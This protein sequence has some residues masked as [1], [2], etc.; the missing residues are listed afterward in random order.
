MR[1]ASAWRWGLALLGIALFGALAMRRSTGWIV[2]QHLRLSG[3]PAS[4]FGT[5]V[6]VGVKELPGGYQPPAGARADFNRR[7]A[8]AAE[9]LRNDPQV[10][11]AY[12]LR[13]AAW[14]ARM[15]AGAEE[16]TQHAAAL[17]PLLARF[18]ADPAVPATMV[19]FDLQRSILSNRREEEL[20]S[21]ASRRRF[22]SLEP[23]PTPLQLHEYDKL[24][25]RGERLAPANALFP[26][27]R[28][29]GQLEA[30]DDRAA[31]ASL[32]RAASCA[33]WED[34]TAAE[35]QG[36]WR[37]LEAAT[38]DRSALP[39]LAL[40]GA[41]LYP[42]YARFR[43]VARILTVRAMQAEQA[44]RVKEGVAIRH[45]L[46]QV[47]GRMRR[48]SSNAI[49]ALVG[50]AINTVAAGRPGG[51][52]PPREPPLTREI[53]EEE[54][55]ARSDKRRH[56]YADYLRANGMGPEAR[57]FEAL[58]TEDTSA[59]EIVQK[60]VRSND[61]MEPVIGATAGQ[62]RSLAAILSMAWVLALGALGAIAGLGPRIGAGD[63]MTWPERGGATAGVVVAI[64]LT[65]A[66]AVGMLPTVAVACIYAAAVAA[67]FTLRRRGGWL[68]SL[69]NVAAATGLG[70]LAFVVV[71]RPTLSIW[72]GMAGTIQ[73]LSSSS[74]ANV[75]LAAQAVAPWAQAL[76]MVM[77]LTALLLAI[78]AAIR[79]VPVSVA[80]ARGWSA[81]AVP[82]ALILALAYGVSVR[83]QARTEALFV[84]Q[85]EQR[86]SGENQYY[87][88]RLHREWP[89]TI[90]GKT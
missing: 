11:I 77:P 87:A 49:G 34:Y 65:W 8:L 63:P 50:I 55:W 75:P 40:A 32:R 4:A 1:I 80:F 59:R 12:A 79:R 17:R 16:M 53:T 52:L 24:C 27:C 20:L 74:D 62:L 73:A 89:R 7:T 61:W 37:L 41:I 15:P 14:S 19:R 76:A 44:G 35:L 66:L 69:S 3:V 56:L 72:L 90:G 38:D 23:P 5:L 81:G 9:R 48:D 78:G 54:R 31:L 10:A 84:R 68:S 64:A 28:A 88:A 33:N 47:G 29:I 39:R 36:Q 6:D 46:M 22:P 86:A 70:L 58:G 51:I 60:A 57:W 13:Q 85:V 30:G 2:R 18:P 21:P 42:H 45:A 71:G 25:A 67:A 83:S 82:I 43:T 26:L